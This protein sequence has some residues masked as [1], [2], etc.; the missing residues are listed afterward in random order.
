MTASTWMINLVF[1]FL[2]NFNVSSTVAKREIDRTTIDT[3]VHTKLF[4]SSHLVSLNLLTWQVPSIF[5][6]RIC[7][8]AILFHSSTS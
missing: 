7:M 3:K 8:L 5:H 1:S 4:L 6:Y 2:L